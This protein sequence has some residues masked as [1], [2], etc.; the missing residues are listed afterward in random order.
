VL[1]EWGGKLSGFV[2]SVEE[3]CVGGESC[4]GGEERYK[5]WGRVFCWGRGGGVEL[6]G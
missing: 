3:Y 2:R 5:G 6:C 1:Y 4:V